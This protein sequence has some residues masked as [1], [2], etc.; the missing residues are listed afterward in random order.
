M[1]ACAKAVFGVLVRVMRPC[2]DCLC[3]CLQGGVAL[4]VLGFVIVL[5]CSVV[6]KLAR[7][8]REAC[9]SWAMEGWDGLCAASRVCAVGEA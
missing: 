8:G 7:K 6:L 2:A 5:V 4:L 9:K 1:L 3:S